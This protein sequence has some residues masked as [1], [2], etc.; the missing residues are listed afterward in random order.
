MIFATFL[1]GGV[2]GV[3]ELIA[4]RFSG[5]IPISRRCRLVEGSPGVVRKSFHFLANVGRVMRTFG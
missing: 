4:V 1:I 3:M 5:F 2:S